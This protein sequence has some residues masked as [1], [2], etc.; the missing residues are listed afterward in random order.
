L[1]NE[2]LLPVITIETKEPRHEAT[3]AEH[4]SYEQRLPHYTTLREAFLTDGF[5]WSQLI[6]AAPAGRQSIVKR[7]KID[8]VA[9]ED[10]IINEFLAPLAANR[11]IVDIDE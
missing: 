1:L 9:D 7:S 4:A 5:R 3:K 2:Q 6:L 10:V 8:I 11:Y